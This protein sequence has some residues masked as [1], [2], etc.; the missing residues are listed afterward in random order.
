MCLSVAQIVLRYRTVICPNTCFDGY[1]DS[2]YTIMER[3]SFQIT[4]LHLDQKLAKYISIGP[5]NQKLNAMPQIEEKHEECVWL[6]VGALW[7][8]N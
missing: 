6:F 1:A 3:V 7:N 5:V 8:T 4:K 2:N